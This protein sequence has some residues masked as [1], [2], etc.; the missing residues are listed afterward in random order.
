[1]YMLNL[2]PGKDYLV[3]EHKPNYP[4]LLKGEIVRNGVNGEID[5][6]NKQVAEMVWGTQ[7]R[8]YP[9]TL[10]PSVIKTEQPIRTGRSI[11]QY[12]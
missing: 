4:S 2:D 10:Q 11:V 9:E 3:V 8:M 6:F 12:E 1:M 5:E 7:R